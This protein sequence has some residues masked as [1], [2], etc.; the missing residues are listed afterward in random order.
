M[1]LIWHLEYLCKVIVEEEKE[2]RR[3]TSYLDFK[4]IKWN[5]NL[6]HETRVRKLERQ[7]TPELNKLRHFKAK[8]QRR[9]PCISAGY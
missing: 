7:P 6:T 2:R 3:R 9:Q 1:K 4:L 8:G 5:R